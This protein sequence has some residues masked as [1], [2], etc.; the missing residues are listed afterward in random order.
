MKKIYAVLIVFLLFIPLFAKNTYADDTVYS[1]G[2]FYYTEKEESITITG[3]FGREKRVVVPDNIAGVPVN[4]IA[5]GAFAGTNVEVLYLPETVV[6]VGDGGAGTAKVEYAR[7]DSASSETIN[8]S[9]E[10]PTKPTPTGSDI[11]EV[12]K[13]DESMGVVN[14]GDI[15]NEDGDEKPLQQEESVTSGLSDNEKN[16]DSKKKNSEGGVSSTSDNDFKG[17]KSVQEDKSSDNGKTGN[18]DESSKDDASGKSGNTLDD[19]KTGRKQKSD[20]NGVSGITDKTT[21]NEKKSEEITGEQSSVSTKKK[22]DMGLSETNSEVAKVTVGEHEEVT[23]TEFDFEDT[24]KSVESGIADINAS[25]KSIV[26]DTTVRER[27][28]IVIATASPEDIERVRTEN[29]AV[30]GSSSNGSPIIWVILAAVCI[31]GAGV[32]VYFV[33][34]KNGTA[35]DSRGK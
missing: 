27:D 9:I 31:C 1:E 11:S 32:A 20:E 4:A 7:E 10:E 24:D 29:A 18:I 6:F 14:S 30:N 12:V 13:K 28:G 22:S 3:Y 26:P 16:T 34:K 19:E 5:P 15:G 33:R 35:G 17:D 2:Y 8:E 25:E 23:V 21:K